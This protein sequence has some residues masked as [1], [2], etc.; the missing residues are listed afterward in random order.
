M[1]AFALCVESESSH[2]LNAPSQF[3]FHDSNCAQINR[4]FAARIVK[5]IFKW[6]FQSPFIILNYKQ[7]LKSKNDK[8][9]FKANNNPLSLWT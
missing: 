4:V 7:N 2:V 5:E 3:K 6:M 9:H 8:D 1:L